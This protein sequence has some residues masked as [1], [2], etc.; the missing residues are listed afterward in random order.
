MWLPSAGDDV[1]I[2]SSAEQYRVFS[3]A[4]KNGFV[5]IGVINRASNHA[6]T[7]VYDLS[8]F[9][10][11]VRLAPGL[12]H[13]F[14]DPAK[15]LSHQHFELS[16][17]ALRLRNAHLVDPFH[18]I[19][20]SQ[21]DLLPHQADAVYRHILPQPRIRF[22]LADDPGLGKTIMAGLVLKELK[23]R[24]AADRVLIVVPAHLRDQW[25]REISDWFD[26]EFYIF[27][28]QK[29]AK[30]AN[31]LDVNK[32]IIT[33]LDFAKRET[34]RNV[35]T[36]SEHL[37]DLIIF[38]EAH[39]LSA[40]FYG[41]KYD[42]TK[43][44]ELAQHLIV[45]ANHVLFLTA[46][47]H[48]GNDAE[49]WLRLDL[50]EP[51]MFAN[52]YQM[53]EAAQREGGIPFVLR[54]SKDYVTD[55]H[56]TALF[57]PR[58]V[59]TLELTMSPSEQMV[60]E[61]VTDYIYYWYPTSS[62]LDSGA[63]KVRKFNISLALTVLQR[64]VTSGMAA[65]YLSLA[66]RKQKLSLL[67]T[68]WE[69]QQMQQ[70]ALLHANT[71]E[72]IAD[73]DDQLL[74]EWDELQETIEATTAAEDIGELREEIGELESLLRIVKKLERDGNE[75]KLAEVRRLINGSLKD[76]PNEKLL[77]FSEFKDTVLSLK[78]HLEGL[79]LRVAVIHGGLK[80]WERRKQEEYFRDVA[81]VMVATDAA[82]EGINLQF[83]RLMVNYDLPWNP[84][85]LEQRMGRIHRYGQ[86][87][88]CFIWNLLYENTRE[89]RILSRL[90]AKIEKM[91]SLPELGD[92]IY[93]VVSTVLSGISLEKL[94]MDAVLT[95]DMAE[96]DHVIDV[97]LEE[98]VREYIDLL[99][100]NALAASYINIADVQAMSQNSN[101]EQVTTD[102]QR[103]VTRVADLIGGG[104][105]PDSTL[106]PGVYRLGIPSSMQTDFKDTGYSP[107]LRVTF[108]RSLART[109]GID[110]L[111]IGHPILDRMFDI[112]APQVAGPQIALLRAG[113]LPDGVLCLYRMAV[114][115][116]YGQVAIERLTAVFGPISGTPRIVDPRIVRQMRPHQDVD[117]DSQRLLSCL[118]EIESAARDE[119][120]LHLNDLRVELQ[121]RRSRDA[122]LKHSWLERSFGSTVHDYEQRIASFQ[123]RLSLGE[124]NLRGAITTQE[125]RLDN[126]RRKHEQRLHKLKR[127]TLLTSLSPELKAIALVV[128]D[129]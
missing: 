99:N 12:T 6:Q 70:T 34:N 129:N 110:F 31:F 42:A 32:Q 24:G 116:G 23:A 10:D 64:R 13:L 108:D 48:N 79:G 47:P 58:T 112:Y 22:L 29:Q 109:N 7:L 44:Y 84:N 60:Y 49:Y 120:M 81:Q 83:C 119:A 57:K 78:A 75:P 55:I 94:I 1:L 82:A 40:R 27:D 97:D 121:S 80:M 89:G 20:V 86:E 103:F 37:W 63:E 128:G 87:R 67:L 100:D 102:L 69:Q 51:G 91:K 16:V 73:L 113:D 54:R 107:G 4:R 74:A 43:R 61:A 8:E 123:Y 9:S 98:R 114:Q 76:H 71:A 39:K 122:E 36:S 52:E 111:A 14:K 117:D 68:K 124:T 106:G 93:D 38:D 30:S 19:N 118:T 92:T 18:A 17:E 66:R 65:I 28:N 125:R 50:L 127:E 59:K 33:S 96:I 72:S 21:I 11:H 126:A 90:L 105:V 101:Y 41:N 25:K 88:E 77:I 46:T 2:D 115:D 85:R 53:R 95:G 35:L 3:C 5:E 26:E 104:V 62:N 45:A 15:R 56:G